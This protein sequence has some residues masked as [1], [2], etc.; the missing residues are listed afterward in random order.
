MKITR[1]I[2]GKTIEIELTP[3]EINAAYWEQTQIKTE[4]EVEFCIEDYLDDDEYERLKD[5][6]DFIK[7][8]AEDIQDQMNYRGISFSDALEHAIE[9]YKEDYLQ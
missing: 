3:E 1:I 2:N 7:D 9:E 6:K 5:N 4:S 8:I